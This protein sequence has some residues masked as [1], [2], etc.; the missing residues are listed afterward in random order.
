MNIESTEISQEYHDLIHTDDIE[1]P[2][3]E[4]LCQRKRE[5]RNSEQMEPP[6]ITVTLFHKFDKHTDTLLNS[7]EPFIK[8]P[9]ILV[10]Q[11]CDPVLVISKR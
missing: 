7:M 1:L 5:T 3:E 6:V 8:N 11:D 9:R 10:E 4:P 2:S